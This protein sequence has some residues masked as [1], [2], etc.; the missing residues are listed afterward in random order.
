MIK[1]ID[2]A[3]N[4]TF[5]GK[6]TLDTLEDAI[7]KTNDLEVDLDGVTINKRLTIYLA[8][9]K[10]IYGVT[11]HNLDN[12]ENLLNGYV[13]SYYFLKDELTSD[14][15]IKWFEG[16]LEMNKWGLII[17]DNRL[18]KK[19]DLEPDLE[20]ISPSMISRGRVF[21]YRKLRTLYS[22]PIKLMEALDQGKDVWERKELNISD[23]NNKDIGFRFASNERERTILDIFEKII[24]NRKL[25]LT[26]NTENMEVK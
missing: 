12:R 16:M 9:I 24:T 23:L 19:S 2:F 4:N 3:G 10:A 25:K 5:V 17:K 7:I 26:E 21:M 18:S 14:E 13:D 22:E 11:Y 15:Y 6:D 8:R 20:I 1:L